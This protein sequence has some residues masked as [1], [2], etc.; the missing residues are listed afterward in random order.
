MIASI[1]HNLLIFSSLLE[2]CLQQ[3]L[4]HTSTM[5]GTAHPHLKYKRQFSSICNLKWKWGG[6]GYHA[7]ELVSERIQQVYTLVAQLIGIEKNDSE[8]N[9][10]VEIALV[11]SATVGW[12][13][14][15]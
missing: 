10:R 12:T 2:P 1:L 4:I 13:R 15:F 8:Y 6:G 11:K 5:L 9:S 3:N 7:E 14:V